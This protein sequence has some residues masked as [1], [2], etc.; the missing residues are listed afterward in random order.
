MYVARRPSVLL[1]LGRNE[2]GVQA[3]ESDKLT[4]I[5]L[6]YNPTLIHDH[7]HVRRQDCTETVS[8]YQR[9]ASLH[10]RL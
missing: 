8:D 2:P 3:T 10:N 7:N 5:S 1:E 4:V 9:G 6:L